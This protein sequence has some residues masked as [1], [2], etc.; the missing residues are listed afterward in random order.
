MS[1]E[2]SSLGLEPALLD[3]LQSMGF[4]QMTEIQA[5]TLP[6]ILAG[7]DVVAKAKTGSGKTAAFGLALLHNLD[8]KRFR[9]QALVMCPTRELAEQVALEIRRLGRA[10][11]NI[12]V[13]TLCG[14][15]PMGPQIGSLEHGAHIIVGTPGRIMDHL[16]KRRLDLSEVN[17]LVLDEADRMLDMGFED[18]MDAV[19]KSVPEQRQ[20]LLFSATYPDSIAA[21]SGQVQKNPLEVTVESTHD[22]DSIQQVFFEVD[23]AQRTKATAALLSHY[24]PESAIVFCNTKIACQEV[25]E[26]LK[27]LGVSVLALH[28]DLEQRERNQ[29]L[30]RFANKSVSVLVATDV[31]SRGLDIKEVNAVISYHITPDPEV[32]IHRIGRTGRAESKGVALTLVAPDE[33]ARANAIEDYQ[34]AKLKWTGIQ[35]MRFH[36]NRLVQPQYSTLCVDGGKKAKLRPGDL[37]GALTKQAEIPGDD[38]GKIH[39]TEFHAYLAVKTRSVKRAMRQLGEGKI[40]GK[41]FKVRKFN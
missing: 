21:I 16:Y 11:H 20:T 13:L 15:T 27:S 31:A 24:Q 30:V 37:L 8:V 28:G 22:T 25:A 6:A 40:K 9:V 10:I 17:T 39:I 12:K 34:K 1:K 14:G 33:M 41:K 19:I 38:I 35:A 4:S 2:F 32:H 18:E 29:V 23:D 7:R 5:G 3:N 36:V 26:E